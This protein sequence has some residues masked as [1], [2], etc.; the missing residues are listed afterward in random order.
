MVFYYYVRSKWTM[1]LLYLL[2]FALSLYLNIQCIN[3][4]PTYLQLANFH[5]H[6][7]GS[8]HMTT[9]TATKIM[10]MMMMM[11]TM[12]MHC[13]SIGLALKWKNKREFHS[14][15]VFFTH[16]LLF[17]IVCASEKWTRHI[18]IV[19]YFG[20]QK[21]N[22]LTTTLIKYIVASRHRGVLFTRIKIPT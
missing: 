17:W 4:H 7:Y 1:D 10:M 12:M 9:T 14:P 11:I 3:N 21:H 13:T 20:A 8:A 2:S 16:N 15:H 22:T 18:H 6:Q 19:V 5:T